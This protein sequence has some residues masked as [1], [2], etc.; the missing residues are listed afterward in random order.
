METGFVYIV[1]DTK[2]QQYRKRR[3]QTP[4]TAQAV[5]DRFNARCGRPRYIIYPVSV[6]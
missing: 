3:Y 4:E 5:A 2:T 1:F 6:F